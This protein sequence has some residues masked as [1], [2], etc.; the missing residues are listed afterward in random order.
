MRNQF[1]CKRPY[2]TK[3]EERGAGSE[4][5]ALPELLYYYLYK[6]GVFICVFI[7]RCVRRRSKKKSI[8]TLLGPCIG[9]LLVELASAISTL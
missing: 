7:A 1:L 9:L 3:L 2:Q 4:L 8:Y 5:V 6:S